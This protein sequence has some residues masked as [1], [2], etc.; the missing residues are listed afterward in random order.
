MSPPRGAQS[1]A[2]ADGSAGVSSRPIPTGAGSLELQSPR[3]LFRT[4]LLA[5]AAALV[6]V[7]C[8]TSAVDGCTER[9]APP[10]AA[11]PEW[12]EGFVELEHPPP[13]ASASPPGAPPAPSAER[14]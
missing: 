10:A 13:G 8:F 12:P 9:P 4:L 6:G 14:R 5:A 1:Q 11:A 3:F 7:L 2:R